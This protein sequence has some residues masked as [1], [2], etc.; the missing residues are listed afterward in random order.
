MTPT[1]PKLPCHQEQLWPKDGSL[2]SLSSLVGPR[3]WL[4]FNLLQLDEAE[5]LWLTLPSN[6]W[7]D[8][9]G[10]TKLSQFLSSLEVVNDAG[11]RAV[12]LMQ[13]IYL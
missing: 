11:E 7:L 10:F 4:L 8:H 12:K 5:L 3:T 6:V 9:L 2:P 1:L 13:V